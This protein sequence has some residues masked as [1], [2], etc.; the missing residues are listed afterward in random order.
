[1]GLCFESGSKLTT[2]EKKLKCNWYLIGKATKPKQKPTKQKIPTSFKIYYTLVNLISKI[3]TMLALGINAFHIFYSSAYSA[4]HRGYLKFPTSTNTAAYT[5][6]W[7]VV[8]I[9]LGYAHT[10]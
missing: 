7:P 6:A 3:Q 1:M 4:G 9:H 10:L 5:F 8:Y 2:F